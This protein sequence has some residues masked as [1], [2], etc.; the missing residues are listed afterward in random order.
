MK[1]DSKR[2]LPLF[3]LSGYI[4]PCKHNYSKCQIT[5]KKKKK[6]LL[7][8]FSLYL[9]RWIARIASSMV[10]D[11]KRKKKISKTKIISGLVMILWTVPQSKNS[12]L[13]AKCKQPM[14][15]YQNPRKKLYLPIPLQVLTHSFEDSLNWVQLGVVVVV[16]EVQAHRLKS[17][18]SDLRRCKE[19]SERGLIDPPVVYVTWHPTQIRWGELKCTGLAYTLK[20]SITITWMIPFSNDFYYMRKKKERLSI[21]LKRTPHIHNVL[22][23]KGNLYFLVKKSSMHSGFKFYWIDNV[24]YRHI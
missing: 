2:S 3:S 12:S 11:Q 16:G 24:C 1:S 19:E 4:T 20:S 22:S 7:S 21:D 13:V 10:G 18:P 8:I 6:L 17:S 14:R 15:Q 5:K 23:S 9:P